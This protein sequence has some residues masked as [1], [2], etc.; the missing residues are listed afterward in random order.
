M[1]RYLGIL[2]NIPEM[3]I[4]KLRILVS[5]RDGR[6]VTLI[7]TNKPLIKTNKPLIKTNKSRQNPIMSVHMF[8]ILKQLF[9]SGFTSPSAHI[10]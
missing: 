1:V 9:T 3:E 4:T 5:L 10:C 7:K 8:Y 2:G 6:L